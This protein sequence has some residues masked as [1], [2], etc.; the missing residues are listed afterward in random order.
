MLRVPSK[1]IADYSEDERAAI[2]GG[3]AAKFYGIQAG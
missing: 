2:L 1:I 3:T